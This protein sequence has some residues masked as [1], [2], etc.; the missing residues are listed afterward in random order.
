MRIATVCVGSQA[1][2]GAAH[3]LRRLLVAPGVTTTLVSL[4]DLEFGTNLCGCETGVWASGRSEESS[5]GSLQNALDRFFKSEETGGNSRLEMYESKTT[6]TRIEE[7]RIERGNHAHSLSLTLYLSPGVARAACCRRRA[8]PTQERRSSARP[9]P[10]RVSLSLT[11]ERER[12]RERE[13]ARR[14]SLESALGRGKKVSLAHCDASIS[15]H[16]AKLRSALG[17]RRSS[18]VSAETE[19]GDGKRGVSHTSRAVPKKSG[20]NNTLRDFLLLLRA[21]SSRDPFEGFFT[22]KGRSKVRQASAVSGRRRDARRHH[23]R[24]VARTAG[25][26]LRRQRAASLRKSDSDSLKCF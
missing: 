16:Q 20:A 12:E 18:S 13:R 9:C 7:T 10:S 1:R 19:R 17:L 11:V 15:A 2:P 21:R 8:R 6:G 4:S 26:L 24:V 14:T 5:R 3:Q 22:P 25:T 23:D